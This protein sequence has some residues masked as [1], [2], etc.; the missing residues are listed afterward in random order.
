MPLYLDSTRLQLNTKIVSAC[1]S[2]RKLIF[3]A[4]DLSDGS[5]LYISS[6]QKFIY[7]VMGMRPQFFAI[8]LS[9]GD[10]EIYFFVIILIIH[11]NLK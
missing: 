11:W 1:S 10:T 3:H 8:F 6:I 5:L 2:V 7:P 4:L 9:S